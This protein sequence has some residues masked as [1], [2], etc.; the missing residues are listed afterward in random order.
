MLAR[1]LGYYSLGFEQNPKFNIIDQ[2]SLFS[3]HP[4]LGIYVKKRVQIENL[5][6]NCIHTRYLQK[7]RYC[8]LQI[9]IYILFV[10]H[11]THTR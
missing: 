5:C 3:S 6:R 1:V 7:K 4:V 2:K 9:L 10:R 11:F 8:D